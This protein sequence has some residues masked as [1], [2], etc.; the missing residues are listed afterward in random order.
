MKKFYFICCRASAF[1]VTDLYAWR[2]DK[3]LRLLVE[4]VLSG[5]K[6]RQG[7]L[8][9]WSIISAYS[10]MANHKNEVSHTVK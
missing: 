1:L 3:H 5:K 8:Y 9:Y 7:D 10:F 2:R 4:K 6:Q